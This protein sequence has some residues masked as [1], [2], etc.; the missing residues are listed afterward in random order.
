MN[1][2]SSMQSNPEHLA[3]TVLVVDDEFLVR[4]YVAD[5]L[6]EEGFRVIEAIN[7]DEAVSILR[8]SAP[9]DVVVTDLRMPGAMDGV[10]LAR[11]IRERRPQLKII[12]TSGDLSGP[13]AGCRLDGFFMKPYRL[14][15]L[16][17]LIRSLPPEPGP[18]ES[19]RP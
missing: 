3:S 11:F 8:T 14:A 17:R 19:E 10:G 5:S 7:G 12:M 16:A 13:P 4:L 18:S 2:A 9:V 15:D 6:R 1:A